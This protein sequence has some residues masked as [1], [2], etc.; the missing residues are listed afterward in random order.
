MTRRLLA[1]AL[2]L[3]AACAPA[4][5]ARVVLITIDTL[6]A[7]H[8]GP[9]HGRP[10]LTPGL[11]SLAADGVTYDDAV[12][13]CSVTRCSHVSLLTGLYPWHHEVLDNSASYDGASLPGWLRERGFA[14]GAVLSSLPVKD[15]VAGFEWSH[16][17]FPASEPARKTYPVKLPEQTNRAAFEF[18]EREASR[19]FFLWV[20]YFPPHGPYTPGDAYLR[21]PSRDSGERLRVSARNYEKGRIPAYQALPGVLD[22]AEYRRRYAGHV[23]Y[24]DHFVARLL[25]RLRETGVYED[26][27]IVAT[28]DH[29]ESLGEH[30]WY[31]V[32]GNLVYQEQAR[33]PLVVKWP[34]A[35]H[36]G[37][38]ISAPVEL[39]DVAPT[40][41]DSLAGPAF[42]ADGRP[43]PDPPAVRERPRLRYSQSNDAEVVAVWNGPWKLLWKR[44]PTTYTDPGH[45]A[46]ELFRLDQDPAEGRDLGAEQP[47]RLRLMQAGLERR[48]G[49]AA[50]LPD[51]A[52][53][54][55]EEALRALGYVE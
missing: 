5:P 18:L 33:V 13:N 54:E 6:R 1:P 10:S 23:R 51:S 31:F 15:L 50:A 47:D 43:L 55:N 8:V 17:G 4:R 52:T 40:L 36:A 27:L 28:S 34:G 44:G 9:G 2:V 3:A 22:A 41:A 30:G 19:P 46:L 16:A 12:A 7:D 38:R 29:G 48:W 14:T 37:T 35:R 53:P 49:R 26:A 11:D 20:H 24:V 39:V 42:A 45:P 25:D 32:H 21:G